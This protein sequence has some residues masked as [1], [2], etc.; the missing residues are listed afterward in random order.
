MV[1]VSGWDIAAAV[2]V[3]WAIVTLVILVWKGKFL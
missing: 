2:L 3:G 1:G